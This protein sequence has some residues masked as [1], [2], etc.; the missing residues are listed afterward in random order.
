MGRKNVKKMD[1]NRIIIILYLSM[2]IGCTINEKRSFIVKKEF[3]EKGNLKLVYYGD[4]LAEGKSY[5][6]YSGG[7]KLTEIN[8]FGSKLNGPYRYFFKSR[9][10]REEFYI[11][12][13]KNGISKYY[14]RDGKIS[15]EGEYK[16]DKKHGV[17]NYYDNDKL[18]LSEF[19]NSGILKE[20][21]FEDTI[22]IRS[23]TLKERTLN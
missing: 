1:I 11:N 16:D 3:Y 2:F 23:D 17:W 5:Y 19:Y 13:E 6:F 21:V 9:L 14:T 7:E 22:A 20:K 4:T 12:G 15:E 10:I 8:Y 18:I